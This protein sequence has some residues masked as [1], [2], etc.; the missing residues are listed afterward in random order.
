MA[1]I[2]K[3]PKMVPFQL[4]MVVVTEKA[5]GVMFED[6]DDED[7]LEWLPLSEIVIHNEWRHGGSKWFSGKMPKWLGQKIG[8]ASAFPEEV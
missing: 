5:I 1:S 4:R 2:A 3:Y 7:A 6:D 8:L